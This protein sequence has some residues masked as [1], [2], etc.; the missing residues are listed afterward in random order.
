MDRA[1]WQQAQEI[2]H[3][4]VELEGDQQ[5]TALRELC[6]G[7]AALLEQLQGMLEEDR[8]NDFVLDNGIA[9][10]AE[11]FVGS[12]EEQ[13][14]QHVEQVGPYRIER[15]LGEGG[16][17][18]VYLAERTDI[19]GRVAIKL[20]RDAWVSPARRRRFASEQRTLAQLTSTVFR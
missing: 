6:V 2:F 17:G 1:V 9:A 13:H 14:W 11:S 3:K 5:E 18:I 10:V 19:G 7:D 15:L 4:V 12:S 16:M 8:R 20:L